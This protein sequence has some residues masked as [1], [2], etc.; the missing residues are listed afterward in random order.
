MYLNK[1]AKLMWLPGSLFLKTFN[2][3]GTQCKVNLLHG[4]IY[5]DIISPAHPH[6]AVP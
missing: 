3:A 1:A 6:I 4:Q 5:S 2:I